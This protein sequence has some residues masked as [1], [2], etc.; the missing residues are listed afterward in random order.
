MSNNPILS[1]SA[2][3]AML[4]GVFAVPAGCYLTG[5]I[6]I[7]LAF[8]LAMI[9]FMPLFV[10]LPK[11]IQRG[12]QADA[13]AVVDAFGKNEHVMRVCWACDHEGSSRWWGC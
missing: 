12:I 7:A 13:Q 10:F 4:A 9:V 11:L 2:M 6:G 1:G 3:S 8:I 5:R